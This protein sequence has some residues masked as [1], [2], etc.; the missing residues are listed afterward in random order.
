VARSSKRPNHFIDESVWLAV[1]A[2]MRLAPGNY[3]RA[4]ERAGTTHATA[5]KLWVEG[6]PGTVWG[7]RP[8][9]EV[10]LDE[11]RAATARAAAAA[12][13][14]RGPDASEVAEGRKRAIETRAEE[15]R[16][17]TLARANVLGVLEGTTQLTL[18]YLKLAKQVDKTIMVLSDA[19][20]PVEQRM[21]LPQALLT[22]S[23]MAGIVGKGVYAAEAVANL[24]RMV[25]GD[26]KDRIGGLPDDREMTAEEALEALGRGGD[27]ALRMERAGLVVLQ[28]GRSRVPTPLVPSEPPPPTPP[29]EETAANGTG[30]HEDE[31]PEV[32]D[33][34]GETN[35]SDD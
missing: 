12:E 28:G 13:L 21:N 4:A 33:T 8:M 34:D 19:S 7:A 20:T 2:A 15:G 30:R 3:T 9:R 22:L 26:P 32:E 25:L 16:I 23:R 5:K 14:G 11:Q 18:T 10:F 35:D 31:E 24:E 6:K 1:I 29:I 27:M 17:L